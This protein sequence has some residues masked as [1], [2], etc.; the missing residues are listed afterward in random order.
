MTGDRLEALVAG[1]LDDWGL[2]VDGPTIHGRAG[3]VVPVLAEGRRPCV[4]KV[5]AQGGVAEEALALKLWHGAGAVRLVSADPHRSALLLERLEPTDLGTTWDLDACGVVADL[6][7]RL[8][9]PAPVQL[10]RLS[11][12]TAGWSTALAAA[13]GL[14][15]PP[16]LVQEAA[17]LAR[18]LATDEATDGVVVHTDLHYGN[19]LRTPEDGWCAIAPKPLSGDPHSELAPMLWHRLDDYAGRVRD[20]VRDR[21]F[22]LVDGAELDED[23]ARAWTVVRLMVAVLEQPGADR[24]WTTAMLSVAKAVRD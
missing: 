19:V 23:R 16:R 20:G 18:D 22:A 2:A 9:V 17:S 13:T 21:F 24:S 8:H 15:V 5:V 6:Y 10:T 7:R 11:T 12:R 1:L 3:V 14:P 4:L